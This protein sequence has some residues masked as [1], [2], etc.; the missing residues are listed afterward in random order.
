MTYQWFKDGTDL[1][2][3]D[4]TTSYTGTAGTYTVTAENADGCIFSSAP[5][6]VTE[7]TVS[8]P[9]SVDDTDNSLEICEG[10]D[11]T[12]SFTVNDGGA[13]VSYQWQYQAVGATDYTDIS[14]ATNEVL[15]FV[16]IAQSEQGAYRLQVSSADCTVVS[17]A[18]TVTILPEP[19]VTINGAT[20][21]PA[22]GTPITLTLVE[23][24]PDIRWSN[25]E[26]GTNTIEVSTPGVYEVLVFTADNC[27]NSASVT[28]SAAA[29]LPPP[30]PGAPD[31]CPDIDFSLPDA[32]RVVLETD[33]PFEI[34]EGS[35]AGG[36]YTGPGISTPDNNTFTFTPSDALLGVNNISYTFPNFGQL[37]DDLDGSGNG[38]KY[39]KSVDVNEDGSIVVVGAPSY[40]GPGASQGGQV[41]V[42]RLD[43][44]GDWELLGNSVEGSVNN[45]NFGDEIAINAEGNI[46][47]TASD[48][49]N[50]NDGAARVY[51]LSADESTWELLG[52]PIEGTVGDGLGSTVDINKA[53]NRIALTFNNRVGTN[54]NEGIVQVFEWNGLAWLPEGNPIEK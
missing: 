25:G 53:G 19:S 47:V 22:D 8:C 27:S 32:K 37:G 10:N 33:V 38:D 16:D 29:V 24:Y 7:E 21:L 49:S 17:G 44:S 34:N 39:G 2:L 15:N 18:Y 46:F 6:I 20:T 5:F 52:A 40:D 36:F 11:S 41:Q 30:P 14:G 28:I 9:L 4:D 35:P 23:I 31:E 50:S 12:I 48:L 3:S 1:S 42:F 54:G 13:T 26:N 45:D 51:R 43:G